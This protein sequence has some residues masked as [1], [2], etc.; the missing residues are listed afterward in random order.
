MPRAVPGEKI[1][2]MIVPPRP[3]RDER[4]LEAMSD[5][6]MGAG[7]DAHRAGYLHVGDVVW[8]LW[9]TLITY[10]PERVVS[11]WEDEDGSLLCHPL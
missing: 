10:D 3:Y 4:D 2:G 8:R 1:P 9:D 5:L 7:A 6:L 11:L